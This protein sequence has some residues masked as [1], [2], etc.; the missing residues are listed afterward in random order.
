MEIIP[1]DE[2][3]EIKWKIESKLNIVYGGKEYRLY[4]ICPL[5][6]S[7]H[8]IKDYN[9]LGE[10]M[11]SGQIPCARCDTCEVDIYLDGHIHSYRGDFHNR[12]KKIKQLK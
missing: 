11:M 5:C 4:A 3:S 7:E 8:N 12:D 10:K 9:T 6:D 1:A 2:V